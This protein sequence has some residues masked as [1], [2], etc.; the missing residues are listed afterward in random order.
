MVLR[1]LVWALVGVGLLPASAFALGLGDIHLK[2]QLNAPLDAE[3][4]ITGATAD[5]LTGLKATVAARD[6]FGRYGLDYPDFAQSVTMVPGKS[7]DGHD[8]IRIRTSDS[9][10]EPFAELLVE[11]NWARG[12]LM[13]EYTL[14][15]DPPVFM[16]SAAAAAPA[17]TSPAVAPAARTGAVDRTMNAPASGA[18]SSGSAPSHAE[19][20]G[21]AGGTYTVKRGD[22]LSLIAAR[23][24]S[25]AD[26]ERALVA[27]YRGNSAAFLGNMN[28]LRSGAQL[29]LPD[30]QALGAIGASEASAEVR[31]EYHTWAES[32]PSAA[33]AGQLRLVPPAQSLAPEPAPAPGGGTG[34]ANGTTQSQV[35]Q[36]Q[37]ELTESKRLLE[38][39]NAELARLQSQL[40]ASGNK[41]T[42]PPAAAPVSAT[43]PPATTPVP[44]SSSAPATTPAPSSSS[45][46]T[47]APAAVP[48]TTSSA[49]AAEASAPPVPTAAPAAK[50][51]ATKPATPAPAAGGGIIDWLADNWMLPLIVLVVLAGAVFGW[52]KLRAKRDE[53]FGRSLDRLAEKSFEAPSGVRGRTPDV[54]TQPLRTLSQPQESSF[55]VEE[56]GSHAQPQGL[57]AARAK[58]VAVDEAVSAETGAANIDQGGD[59]LAEADFHMA[60]GLYDQAADLVRIAISREPQRRDLKLKLLEVFFVWGNKDQFLQLARE[61]SSSRAQA[62]PGEWEKIVIMGRQIA[63]DDALFA[64][65]G[66]L[67]GAASA[68]V[69]LNLEGGQ[70]RVDFDL[71]GEPTVTRERST[72]G[73]PG[74]VDLDLGAALG[75]EDPTG[76]SRRLGD[77]GMDFVLDDPAR[78]SDQTGSTR[79]MP[80]SGELSQKT[81]T[82]ELAGLDPDA[83][84]IEQPRLP[85]EDS[86]TIRQKL[87]GLFR[88]G[89]PGADQTAELPI[90]DLGLDLNDP[91]GLGSA[92]DSPT[93]VTRT[94]GETHQLL[95]RAENARGDT[96]QVDQLS[97]SESGTWLF[98]DHDLSGMMPQVGND[99]PTEMVTQLTKAHGDDAG[100]TGEL[101]ALKLEAHKID[102]D[103][104]ATGSTTKNGML[105]LDV[106]TQNVKSEPGF[107]ATHRFEP[108]EIALPDLEPATLSEVGTKLDLARAYMDM[109]DP[110]GARNILEEVLSEGS[111]SQKQ[112]ARRLIDSLPG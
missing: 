76:E 62:L 53:E 5:D 23:N 87:D 20:A 17:V 32:H 91:D 3:I 50:P 86:P 97:P 46:P 12:H 107:E 7:A 65:S 4:E 11:V 67:P 42:T 64:N 26:R 34:K 47:S 106:G 6:A 58:S 82:L 108:G 36:L 70:N 27:I 71:L 94:D 100:L 1:K 56:S 24:Y 112:E 45:A 78:G 63:P 85:G 2:S 88:P 75:A 38:L 48:P 9:I 22:S 49:P 84:T 60:Y 93:M 103:L 29:N 35:T 73:A 61:L 19:P 98:S 33:G 66:A 77:T 89:A 40:A 18:G 15:F 59:P 105:D 111:V 8:I 96:K 57:E 41:G 13:R 43:P 90:D 79:E 104:G 51:P 74:G 68:G 109:G 95:A 72:G 25:P 52:R 16:N 110:E 10:K 14:L 81:V 102:L 44:S 92:S 37:E 83:P 28:V 69:D 99:S 54:S 55:L 39:K 21:A 31:R 80:R 101:E 30:A